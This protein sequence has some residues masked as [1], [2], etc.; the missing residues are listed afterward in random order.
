[1]YCSFFQGKL[2][3]SHLLGVPVCPQS[4]T[5]E[6]HIQKDKEAIGILFDTMMQRFNNTS[7]CQPK[8]SATRSKVVITVT[9]SQSLKEYRHKSMS[10]KA[11]LSTRSERNWVSH[12]DHKKTTASMKSRSR[13][14]ILEEKFNRSMKGSIKSTRLSVHSHTSCQETRGDLEAVAEVDTCDSDSISE[15]DD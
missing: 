2:I 11:R 9:K 14:D 3:C 12:D 10:I 5:M 6:D 13:V 7:L 1:M 15:E 8:Q 4:G